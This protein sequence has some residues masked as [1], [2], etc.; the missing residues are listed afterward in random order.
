MALIAADCMSRYEK[1]PSIYL[2][3]VST[4]FTVRKYFLRYLC[5][6][7]PHFMRVHN[8]TD[9][10][11][12]DGT[13][14]MKVW[15]TVPWYIQPTVWNRYSLQSWTSWLMGLPIPGDEG[16]RYW[17]QG[18]KIH[19]LGPDFMRGKGADYAKESRPKI[20]AERM[21]GCPFVRPK[22]G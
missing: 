17:P 5:L 16:D 13:Y 3:L 15:E 7:R 12:P 1:P 10:P 11:S 2:F 8:I 6:P 18:Y 20:A 4:V 22:V 9:Q 21:K 19:E 14:H